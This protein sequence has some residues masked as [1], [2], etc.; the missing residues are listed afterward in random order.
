MAV[1]IDANVILRY[2][3]DDHEELSPKAAQ[4]IEEREA[5]LLPEVACEVVYVLQKVYK[6]GRPEIQEHLSALIVSQLVRVEQ[7]EVLLKALACYAATSLDFVD[8][9]LWAHHAVDH[10]EVLT[11]DRQL[12]KHLARTQHDGE[13]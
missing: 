11:F 10:D 5:L 8:A 4:I 12:G 3:L 7:A 9:L 1:L 13:N 2:L 6:V